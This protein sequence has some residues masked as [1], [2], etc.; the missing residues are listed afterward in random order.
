MEYEKVEHTLLPIADENSEVLILG[1]MP[2]PKS[3]E[4]GFYYGHPQNRFWK[5][6]AAVYDAPFPRDIEEKTAFLL[7]NHIALWDVL[8]SCRICGASDASIKD[9]M[10]ND[11]VGLLEKTKIDKIYTTGTTAYRLYQKLCAPTVGIDAIPLPSTSPA[12]A[13]MRADDLIRAYRSILL[14][15]FK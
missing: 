5:V 4:V 9:P 12:N 15:S 7:Q 1:T 6:M 10:P 14:N 2:S 3:R 13:R 8:A 11:I